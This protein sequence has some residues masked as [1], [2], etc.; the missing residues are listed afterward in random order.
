MKVADLDL[1]SLPGDTSLEMSEYC[2]NP[3]NHF[4]RIPSCVYS[5][6]IKDDYES[7]L[8]FLRKHRIAL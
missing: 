6:P 7:K 2:A 8:A 1:G 4:W 3:R 5:E